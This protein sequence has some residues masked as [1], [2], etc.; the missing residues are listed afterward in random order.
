MITEKELVNIINDIYDISLEKQIIGAIK[1]T[2]A[3]HGPIGVR[4]ISSAEKRI[5][6]AI[7]AEIKRNILS[8][9]S[10]SEKK[11][12]NLFDRER[13]RVK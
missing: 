13:K 12:D 9:L 6:G 2:I 5:S 7:K 1:S 3:A 4:G 11:L 10:D 8:I